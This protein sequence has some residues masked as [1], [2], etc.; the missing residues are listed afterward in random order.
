MLD[1]DIFVYLGICT[2]ILMV[3]CFTLILRCRKCYV[4]NLNLKNEV[5]ILK[6]KIID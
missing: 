6:S 3:L 1:F 2:I 5:M 4:E